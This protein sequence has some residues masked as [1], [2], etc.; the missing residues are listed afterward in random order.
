MLGLP[1]RSRWLN[2]KRFLKGCTVSHAQLKRTALNTAHRQ[3]NARMIDFG[4]WDMPVTF[5]GTIEEHL[6]VRTAAG[7]FD[8][9][10]MGEL[11]VRGA[12]ALALI[13]HVTTNDASKLQDGQA[14]YTALTTPEGTFVD[15]VLVHRLSA[16]HYLLCVNASNTDKDLQWIVNHNEGFDAEVQDTSAQYTQ[17]ALQG[18]RALEILQPLI[19]VDLQ[20]IKYYWFV[21]DTVDGVPAII[22]RTG[23]TGEDGFE[24][25]FAPA[26][27]E[28]VWNTLLHTGRPLGLQPCGLAA[29]NTLRLEAKMALYGNDI[30]DTTTVY[31]ADLGWI[32]K[33]NKGDFIGREALAR[34]KEQGITRKLIGFEMIERGIARDHYPIVIAGQSVSQ[35]TSGSPAP[36]L[37]KNIGLAYLPLSHTTI[38]AQLQI[39]VR[40][41][42]TTAQVV[43]TPFYKRKL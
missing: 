10:H 7:I 21:Q 16:E 26:A 1:S 3:L 24:L 25:Y 14:Q 19:S 32:V 29:R 31:E 18:P 15:D 6:A 23:Y 2:L 42:L 11:E 40:G 38:G 37:K 41:K 28:Q 36:Y 33:L 43:A 34:Q 22:A 9:S 39:D 5:A 4:G 13:Q 20:A 35:V 30:D 8:V 17:L 27:A 12:E